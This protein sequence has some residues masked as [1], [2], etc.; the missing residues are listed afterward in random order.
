MKTLNSDK[1]LSVPQQNENLAKPLVHLDVLP[2]GTTSAAN[3]IYVLTP[4]HK[5]HI[6]DRLIDLKHTSD[7]STFMLINPK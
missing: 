1:V 5:L 3:E 4:D 6:T 7:Y 2:V